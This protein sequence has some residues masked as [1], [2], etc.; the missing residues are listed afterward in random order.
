MHTFE[1]ET[2]EERDH[3]RDTDVN[4][5]IILKWTINKSSVSVD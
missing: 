3:L 1:P 4:G 5:R 2:L